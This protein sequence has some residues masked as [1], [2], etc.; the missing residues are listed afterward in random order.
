MMKSA[1]VLCLVLAVAFGTVYFQETFDEGWEDRWVVPDT[2][3]NGKGGEWDITTSDWYGDESRDEGLATTQDARFYAIS[4]KLTDEAFSNEDKELVIQYSVKFPQKIDCGGGYVK[5]LPS[6]LD[7]STFSGESDYSIMFGP[8]ICGSTRRTHVIF[9]YN[10]DNHLRTEDIRC[11]SDQ[12]THVYTLIVRPDNSYEVR[13]DGEIK[14]S[15]SLESDFDMLPPK[16]IPDPDVTKP[17]DWVDDAMMEDPDAVKPDDWVDEK[18]I[19]DPDAV[20]PED[21]D[22]ELD[23]EW[24]APLIN[25]VDYKGPW[26]PGLIENPDYIG[27]WEQ[28]MIENPDYEADPNLYRYTDLQYFGIELWQVKS[29]TLFDNII[30][31]D[32]I[33]EAEAF[34]AETYELSKDREKEMFEEAEAVKQA[35]RDAAKAKV[36]QAKAEEDDS[37]EDLFE[38]LFDEDDEEEADDWT[39]DEL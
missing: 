6:S 25:N 18:K 37:E 14:E 29:G 3:S 24:E 32:D 19:V 13:I 10:G 34:M 2:L 35:E 17:D 16:M 31:T 22:D 28:P 27:E 20:K 33:A 9:N 21:W 30:I 38:N 5:L 11:E 4:A 1:V 26:S 8:D 36:E 12:L 7:Q 23:G 39:H 15:G